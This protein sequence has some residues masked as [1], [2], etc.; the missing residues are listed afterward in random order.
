MKILFTNKGL[1]DIKFPLFQYLKKDKLFSGHGCQSLE[2]N[3]NSAASSSLSNGHSGNHSNKSSN[4]NGHGGPAT[5]CT[6][7]DPLTHYHHRN[8]DHYTASF[9]CM[10]RMRIHSQVRYFIIFHAR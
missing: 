1:A 5:P 10:N 6:P 7:G 8:E 3:C 9:A 4:E 2:R